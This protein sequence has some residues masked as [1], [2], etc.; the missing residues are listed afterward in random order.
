MQIAMFYH[1]ALSDWNH[2]NA[3]FLRGVATELAERGHEVVIFE[4]RDAW[5]LK[6]LLASHGRG[7]LRE[8]RQVYPRL[9][10]VRYDPRAFEPAAALEGADLVIV[11]EWNEPALVRRIGWH[12]RHGGRYRLLFHDTHHKA[13]SAPATL[14]ALE[15]RRYDGVLAFGESIRQLY[16]RRGWTGEA[17]TWHEAADTRVFRPLARAAGDAALDL[18][19]IGNWGDEER[20]GELREFLLEPARRL[21]LRARVHGVRYPAE[22]LAA[23]ARAGVD[24]GDWLPN[25]KVPEAF[26]AARVT[27]HVHR[28]PYVRMLP[29]IP[30]IRPFEALACGIPLICSPWEDC[31]GLF[32]IGRDMLMAHDGREMARMLRE[33]LH[34]PELARALAEAGRRAIEARHT[35][36][37]R[38]DE[39]LAI[40]G[41]GAGHD[42]R[43]PARLPMLAAAKMRS[44]IRDQTGRKS[45]GAAA[46][47][48]LNGD[49]K[50]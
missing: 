43:R 48:R 1:S 26:A 46:N 49:H 5:S 29:G 41:E 16:L 45:N 12:R 47:A 6:N 24:Y 31:E 35:C 40:C 19:W 34:E 32:E 30:T 7:P 9:Q 18:I 21:R 8:V 17:W 11:H 39:L 4:P 36:A 33:V 38:V 23:L 25:Y 42:A 20:S 50:S 13:V 3:H 10:V 44:A 22:A 15:L 28:R 2:G 37:H 27:V 14:E